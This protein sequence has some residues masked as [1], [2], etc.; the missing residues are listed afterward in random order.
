M[1]GEGPHHT[2]PYQGFCTLTCGL[3][4]IDSYTICN[5]I[6]V[7][8]SEDLKMFFLLTISDDS[9]SSWWHLELYGNTHILTRLTRVDIPLQ[10][11]T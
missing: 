9:T 1:G 3:C 8:S 7:S 6:H 4:G 5:K 2:K 11:Q 10:L